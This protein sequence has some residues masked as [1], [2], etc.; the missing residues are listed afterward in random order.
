MCRDYP[1]NLLATPFPTFFK[2]CGFRAVARNAE[3]LCRALQQTGLAPD[4]LA[5]L[6]KKL[7][8]E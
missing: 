2:G 5:D 4:T 3:G 6:K 1:G 7:H 8:P